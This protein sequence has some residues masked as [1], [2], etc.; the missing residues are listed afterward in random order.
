MMSFQED[1][2]R[3]IINARDGAMQAALQKVR[4]SWCGHPVTQGI[5]FCSPA[6]LD[7]NRKGCAEETLEPHQ[8]QENWEE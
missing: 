1:I 6:C 2:Q 5:A 7:A 8:R 3:K 4:C